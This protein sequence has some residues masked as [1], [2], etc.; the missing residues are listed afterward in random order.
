MGYGSTSFGGPTSN[1]T[2]SPPVTVETQNARLRSPARAAYGANAGGTAVTVGCPP[3]GSGNVITHQAFRFALDPTVSQ[4]GALASHCGAARFTF[5]WGLDLVK[6]R[7][8]ARHQD[9]ETEVPWNLPA[10]RLEWNQSKDEAAPWWRENWKEA[11]SSGLDALARSLGNFSATR[12]GQRKCRS[13]FPRYRRRGRNDSCRFTTGAIRVDDERHV[14]LPR[15]GRL[16][17]CEKTRAL[18]DRVAA[19]TARVLTATIPREADR[20]FVSFT[21]EVE[22]EMPAGNGHQDTVGID[23]GV[24]RLVTPSTGEPAPGARALQRA[25]RRLRRLGRTVSRRRKGSTRQRRATSRLARTY[26]R[27]RNLRRDYLHKLTTYL[28]KNHGRVVIEDLNVR[29]MMCSARGT[30]EKPGRNVRAKAGLNRALADAAFAEFRR[31]LDYKCRWYGSRLVVA[32]RSFA[33]SRR[34]SGCGQVR[35][36]LSL[37]ERV[38]VC[39]ACGFEIDRDLNAALNL[40]WWAGVKADQVAAS[41]VETQNARGE[42]VGPGTGQADLMEAR[43]RGCLGAR[44]VQLVES[45]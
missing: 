22:R 23:L 35:E 12:K 25:L 26:R 18:R 19:G 3:G 10:L 11:Y 9:D 20:W 4:R 39:A 6:K 32:P 21:C 5:N 42:D 17:T 37:G 14:T 38:F 36:D 43:N 29:G 28:A 24:L 45:H 16:R 2:G 40:V 44:L 30:V 34:C 8:A 1:A 27:V 13:R 33:S 31:L 15:L 41:A 7:L